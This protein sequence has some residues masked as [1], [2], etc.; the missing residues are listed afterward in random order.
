[1]IVTKAPIGTLRV[2]IVQLCSV[3]DGAEQFTDDSVHIKMTTCLKVVAFS[4]CQEVL[5]IWDQMSDRIGIF[6]TPLLAL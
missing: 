2:V 6:G 3:V 1:M 5:K 4:Q